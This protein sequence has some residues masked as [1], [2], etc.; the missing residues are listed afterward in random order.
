MTDNCLLHCYWIYCLCEE[1]LIGF[2]CVVLNWSK[3]AYT[4]FCDVSSSTMKPRK[5]GG[6]IRKIIWSIVN[7]WNKW[8][9]LCSLAHLSPS[10][11]ALETC[12]KTTVF[13][14]NCSA[15]WGGI[16][17]NVNDSKKSATRSF[18]G[19]SAKK[20]S[21]LNYIRVIG[22]NKKQLRSKNWGHSLRWNIEY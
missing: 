5:R 1:W 20:C 12:A 9:G 3:V 2:G 18:W 16:L 14:S 17:R 13:F 10:S 11:R 19:I 7:E 6:G 8:N 22:A 15:H 21:L 4:F